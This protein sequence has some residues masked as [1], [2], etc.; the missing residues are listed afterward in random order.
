MPPAILI[1]ST[2]AENAR[3]LRAPRIPCCRRSTRTC[4]SIAWPIRCSSGT[5]PTAPGDLRPTECR[6]PPSGRSSDRL[7]PTRTRCAQ[8]D[9][10]RRDRHRGRGSE[11]SRPRSSPIVDFDARQRRSRLA[12]QTKP[13][14]RTVDAADRVKRPGRDDGAVLDD[15]ERRAKAQRD[16]MLAARGAIE[17]D[18]GPCCTSCI[19][20]RR[21]RCRPIDA[22][23]R[24]GCPHSRSRRYQGYRQI[25]RPARHHVAACDHIVGRRQIVDHG[26]I[27]NPRPHIT[28]K[29]HPND[30]ADG[31]RAGQIAENE[32]E[33]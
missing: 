20:M 23:L 5:A 3:C 29:I 24:T 2:I 13:S 18:G 22:M 27:G 11:R 26:R 8:L 32:R 4:A 21:P 14:R 28:T 10:D 6:R 15:L 25:P 31:E 33:A 30:H 1:F 17:I 19:V 7:R 16:L 9:S 12:C